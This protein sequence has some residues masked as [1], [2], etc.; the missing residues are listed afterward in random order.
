MTTTQRL[1]AAADRAVVQAAVRAPSV[2]NSQPW[3]FRCTASGIDLSA[4]PTRRLPIADPD[5]R[6]LR[7]AC[8]AALFNIRLA[9]LHEGV[10]PLVTLFPH[11][12]GDL[13]AHVHFDGAERLSPA[14]VPLYAAIP[15]RRTNRK[16]FDE[17]PV[18][19]AVRHALI[20]AAEAEHVRLTVIS[21]ARDRA[22]LRR[23]LLRAH[24][25]QLADPQWVKEFAEW[26]GRT[27][28][29]RDGVRLASSG[30]Q[31]EPQDAW[32]FRDFA[33]GHAAARAPGKDFEAEPMIAVVTSYVDDP[34]AQVQ[35]GEALQ[36]VLLAATSLGLSASFLSQVVEVPSA[37]GKLRALLADG[38]Y[39]QVVLRFGYG[40]PVTPVPRRPVDEVMEFAHI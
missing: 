10:R 11:G 37:R 21:E 40:V 9:L 24:A 12:I 28:A 1:S 18:D 25:D 36:R 19:L 15:R 35:A 5:D 8:G 32:V 30:P 14:E 27:A 22:E 34:F 3:R 7:I 39:P 2:H 38:T 20:S 33:L 29:E 6:E 31:P 16:P 17:Q 26:V 13:I 4:D 23:L